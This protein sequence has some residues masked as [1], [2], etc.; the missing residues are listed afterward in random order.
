MALVASL[1]EK[2]HFG[3]WQLG[4]GKSLQHPKKGEA[5]YAKLVLDAIASLG[6]KDLAWITVAN[7]DQIKKHSWPGKCGYR[8]EWESAC[9]RALSGGTAM[10]R[11]GY[12]NAS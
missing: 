4:D 8:W 11:L 1:I 5:G 6:R 12:F 10:S 2:H 3:R 7:I 9:V